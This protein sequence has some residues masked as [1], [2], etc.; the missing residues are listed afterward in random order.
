MIELK[1]LKKNLL[2]SPLK[3]QEKAER[4]QSQKK[5]KNNDNKRR[6]LGANDRT[7]NS[8]E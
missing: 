1:K 8:L 2:K 7:P 6:K 3:P 5:V 4:K